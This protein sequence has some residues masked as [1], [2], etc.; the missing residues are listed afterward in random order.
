[1]SEFSIKA[2]PALSDNYIWLVVQGAR[3]VCVDP[4]EA[5]PVLARLT[6]TGLHLDEIWITH[7]H[8]DHI[9]GVEALR[10]TF[11]DVVIRAAATYTAATHPVAEGTHW[12]WQGNEVEVWEIPGHTADHIAFLLRDSEGTL[13]IF[14]GDTLFSGGC[15]RVFD[16]SY[17]DLYASLKRLAALPEQ[18]LLYPAHEYTAA[19]R[20]FAADLFP[21]DAV[22]TQAAAAPLPLPS[23]PTRVGDERRT[24][25]F[26]RSH[27]AAIQANLGI[28][29]E[30]ADFET[31]KALRILKNKA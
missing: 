24:N 10:Q 27:E 6:E 2:I 19:N 25:I 16:G 4:G 13:N 26:L 23:L 17:E 29:G 9:G 30:A 3:A 1:M 15:G 5:D 31:F 18:T 28:S 21:E 20:R 22:L 14:C 11:P 8:R 7:R 12:H